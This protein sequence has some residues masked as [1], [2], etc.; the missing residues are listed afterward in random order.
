[1]IQITEPMDRFLA[2]LEAGKVKGETDFF[3]YDVTTRKNERIH[4]ENMITG[5]IGKIFKSNYGGLMNMCSML[6]EKSLLGGIML[7]NQA[8]TESAENIFPPCRA[9]NRLVGHA[10]QTS[11]SSASSTRGNPNGTAS[12]VHPDDGQV[13]FAWDFALEQA[14]DGPINSCALTHPEAGDAGLYPDG[15]LPILKMFG[16]RLDG[17]NVCALDVI[18]GTTWDKARASQFPMSIDSDGYGR[19]IWISGTTFEEM[20]IRHPFNKAELI[21]GPAM[22][23]SANF[24]VVSSRTATL[25]RTFTDKYYMVAQDASNYYVMERA[26]NSDT[27]LYVDIIDK[28]DMSVTSQT[29]TIAG[30]TLARPQLYMSCMYNGI[31]SD[32]NIYWVSG[33]NAKTFVRINMATPADIEVLDTNMTANLDLSMMPI[34]SAAGLVAG[35]NFLINDDTV[36]PCAVHGRLDNTNHQGYSSLANAD[37]SPLFYENECY[38][39]SGVYLRIGSGGIMWLPYLASV[40]NLENPV[41]KNA[42]KT[43]RVQY[44]LTIT[45]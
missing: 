12:W 22:Y 29:I 16:I 28:S 36:Y 19:A 23:G 38:N 31:V 35:R 5:A 33:A 42:N 34:V 45:G 18:G 26:S 6:P 2:A 17:V 14:N 30:A 20:K 37:N 43:M 40:N 25:S 21:E 8:L 32:G 44:T 24:T 11:H 41:D 27:T 10:G 7:F 4:S 9:T 15:T 13:R 1:M 3:L 39:D